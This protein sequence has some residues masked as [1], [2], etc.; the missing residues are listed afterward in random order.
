[1]RPIVTLVL[2]KDRSFSSVV[3][4]ERQKVT[5]TAVKKSTFGGEEDSEPN[6]IVFTAKTKNPEYPIFSQLDFDVESLNALDKIKIDGKVIKLTQSIRSKIK[7]N[8]LK[9][10]DLE[11]VIIDTANIT[12]EVH[13]EVLDLR[14]LEE[15][16]D[17]LDKGLEDIGA[18]TS[19]SSGD[20]AGKMMSYEGKKHL[21][22][23]GPPG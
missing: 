21:L 10:I 18:G 6:I 4:V 16:K 5:L 13:Q 7:L 8:H 12:E 22:L 11:N 3:L 2:N 17:F 14:N 9:I 15:Y 20:I 23:V 19:S 1:M